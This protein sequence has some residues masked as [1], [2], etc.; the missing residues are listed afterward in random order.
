M[1]FKGRREKG[2]PVVN[3]SIGDRDR[4][5]E[6][7]RH[8]AR[9]GRIVEVIKFIK[10]AIDS[11]GEGGRREGVCWFVR[12]PKVQFFYGILGDGGSACVR[13]SRKCV[14]AVVLDVCV[15][16]VECFG[17]AGQGKASKRGALGLVVTLIV[18]I[19]SSHFLDLTTIAL[20]SF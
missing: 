7:E 4:E 3:N 16:L 5:R 1:L 20:L 13:V 9:A 2:V 10:T 12:C 18:G 8:T 17:R 6:R 11:E 15:F 19:G 14:V